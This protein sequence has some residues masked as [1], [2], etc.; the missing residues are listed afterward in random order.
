MSEISPKHGIE[1]D[2][3]GGS[4]PTEAP[5]EGKKKNG[6]SPSA[7][8][9]LILSIFSLGVAVAMYFQ[10]DIKE[11]FSPTLT[12][13]P[14]QEVPLV[15]PK[16]AGL[17]QSEGGVTMPTLTEA[18]DDGPTYAMYFPDDKVV[19]DVLDNPWP[20]YLV[21]EVHA[22]QPQVVPWPVNAYRDSLEGKPDTCWLSPKGT[23][24]PLGVYK[25]NG[26]VHNVVA[27]YF[28]PAFYMGGSSDTI[29][30]CN[31]AVVM[32]PPAWFR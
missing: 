11:F 32:V 29:S 1:F 3:V 31:G 5:I 25:E 12:N 20:H 16:D 14:P 9:A 18:V 17:N 4:S 28:E 30:S 24:R 2:E 6:L 23:L 19:A 26:V 22:P 21:R 7:M 8:A 13:V 27:E 10:A 15:E